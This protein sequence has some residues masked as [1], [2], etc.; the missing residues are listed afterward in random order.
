MVIS[1]ATQTPSTLVI[2]L[3]QDSTNETKLGVGAQTVH[4]SRFWRGWPSA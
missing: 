2:D 3:L 1:S 4:K